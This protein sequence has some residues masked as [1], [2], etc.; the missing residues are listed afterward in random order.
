MDSSGRC[1]REQGRIILEMLM[2]RSFDALRT[3]FCIE[4]VAGNVA[5]ELTPKKA[6]VG[7]P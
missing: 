7:S 3:E 5:N 2:A 1:Y 6:K 4:C